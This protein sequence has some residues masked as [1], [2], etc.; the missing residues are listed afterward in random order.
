MSKLPVCPS[1][2]APRQDPGA[3]VK[4]QEALQVAAATALQQA[5]INPFLLQ[6]ACNPQLAQHL[7][8]QVSAASGGLTPEVNK[9]CCTVDGPQ[10][11][12]H[13]S[14]ACASFYFSASHGCRPKLCTFQCTKWCPCRF[15]HFLQALMQWGERTGPLEMQ[16]VLA[17]LLGLPQQAAAMMQ[18]QAPASMQKPHQQAGLKKPGSPAGTSSI[19]SLT[20]TN[21]FR[22]VATACCQELPTQQGLCCF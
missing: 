13:R 18:H 21:L 11:S 3:Y 2:E 7:Q 15:S 22:A 10:R 14:S 4:L 16:T 1:A 5:G 17:S 12:D 6:Q 9:D 20:G 8:H 19:H